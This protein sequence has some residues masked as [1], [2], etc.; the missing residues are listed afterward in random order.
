MSMLNLNHMMLKNFSSC[1]KVLYNLCGSVLCTKT[2]VG[3][4]IIQIETREHLEEV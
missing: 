4:G 2:I 3:V 1:S